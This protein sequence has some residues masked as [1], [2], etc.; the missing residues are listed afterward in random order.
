MNQIHVQLCL[1]CSD[2]LPEYISWVKGQLFILLYSIIEAIQLNPTSIY[3]SMKESSLML[4]RAAVKILSIQ[5]YPDQQL[6]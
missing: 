1:C 3:N 2:T 6:D 4:S 5:I